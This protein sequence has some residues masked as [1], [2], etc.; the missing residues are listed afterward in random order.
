MTSSREQRADEVELGSPHG[1]YLITVGYDFD[2]EGYYVLLHNKS[3]T[4]WNDAIYDMMAQMEDEGPHDAVRLHSLYEATAEALLDNSMDRG[5]LL[6]SDVETILGI[7]ASATQ[8]DIQRI[9]NLA[10]RRH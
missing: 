8:E 6:L 7:M 3:M 10:N 5:P 4:I 9:T 1:D 2:L